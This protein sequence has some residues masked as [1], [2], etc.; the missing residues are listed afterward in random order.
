MNVLL[1]DFMSDQRLRSKFVRTCLVPLRRASDR[2]LI[3]WMRESDVALLGAAEQVDL[4]ANEIHLFFELNRP[5]PRFEI[6]IDAESRRRLRPFEVG[7][8]IRECLV[9]MQKRN[10]AWKARARWIEDDMD[11]TGFVCVSSTDE[12]TTALMADEVECCIKQM[13]CE[14]R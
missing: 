10:S 9:P 13:M 12:Q 5:V 3:A 7:K 1:P 14:R 4:A 8:L 6:E 2:Q 11:S